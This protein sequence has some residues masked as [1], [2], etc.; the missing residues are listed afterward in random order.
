MTSFDPGLMKISDPEISVEIS[1]FMIP[2]KPIKPV[3]CEDLKGFERSFLTL[4]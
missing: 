3:V 2:E 1:N 4:Q